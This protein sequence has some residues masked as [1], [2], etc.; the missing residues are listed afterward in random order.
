MVESKA[1]LVRKAR[2]VTSVVLHDKTF[3]VV[4]IKRTI[5]GL[6]HRRLHVRNIT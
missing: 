2:Y 1:G 4:K 3:E 6:S 5:A